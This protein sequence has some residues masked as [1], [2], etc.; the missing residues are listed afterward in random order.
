MELTIDLVHRLDARFSRISA[1]CDSIAQQIGNPD[2]ST[3][4]FMLLLADLK[5]EFRLVEISTHGNDFIPLLRYL[6]TVNVHITPEEL[7]ILSF[8]NVKQYTKKAFK[9]DVTFVIETIS[10]IKASISLWE[11]RIFPS[12]N[13][14]QQPPMQLKVPVPPLP[15]DDKFE[16]NAFICHATE[17]KGTFVREL[18]IRLEKEDLKVWY[19]EF[20]LKLG[21]SLRES[22]EKGLSNSRFG[23][24]ILSH[25]FIQKKWPQK[26]LSALHARDSRNNNVI[27]PVWLDLNQDDIASHF[28]LLVDRF[29]TKVEDGM[30]KVVSDI[31]AVLKQ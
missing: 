9:G 10:S 14:T 5:N 4:L 31:V 27:L 15:N 24:V 16:W 30:D 17:D 11:T 1:I 12:F 8:H 6:D 25:A 7:Y 20:S 26:E 13:I 19:D 28:P 21:D 3:Q 23:V 18:C 2:K 22:I 29:A